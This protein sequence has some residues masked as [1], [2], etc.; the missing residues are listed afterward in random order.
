MSVLSSLAG[1]ASEPAVLA[2]LPFVITAAASAASALIPA[3]VPGSKAAVLRAVLD[4]LAFNFGHAANRTAADR[5]AVAIVA[6][7]EPAAGGA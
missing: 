4:Y 1:L 3:P 5:L 7:D 2:V 6:A